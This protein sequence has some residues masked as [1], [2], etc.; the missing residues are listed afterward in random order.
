MNNYHIH[1]CLYIYL[2]YMYSGVYVKANGLKVGSK[3]R[4]KFKEQ[5]KWS[6]VAD[7]AVEWD[8]VRNVTCSFYID[9]LA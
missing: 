6:K 1:V 5:E 3:E 2:Y 8:E 4:L 9:V 7:D